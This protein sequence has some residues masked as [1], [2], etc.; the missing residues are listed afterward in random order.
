MKLPVIQGMISRRILVNYRIN[1]DVASRI[2]PAP[3]R[4]RLHNG[5]SIGGVCLIRLSQLRPRGIPAMLGAGSE[6]AAY[7]F[8]VEWDDGSQCRTGV[9]VPQ[10]LTDSRLN[11]VVG[12][13]L[14]LGVHTYCAF[15]VD[16]SNDR[17]T[18]EISNPKRREVSLDVRQSDQWDDRSVFT[19]LEQA[20]SF[21]EADTIGYSTG[22]D[23]AG[24]DGLE[25]SCLT[26]KVH[27]TRIDSASVAYFED[28]SLFPKGSTI[29]DCALLM[30]EIPHEWRA[31]PK[32]SL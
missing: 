20:S 32:L 11:S 23:A 14:F 13:R 16:E 30:R 27:A 5:W 29:L 3:F 25:L 8:A 12:G 9:F 4:P 28:Q 17:Y 31:L 1:A 2:I 7:R 18:I 10:R 24:F 6:N 21:F 26:W 15:R 19:S 22:R